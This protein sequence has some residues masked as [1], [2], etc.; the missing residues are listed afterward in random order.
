MLHI[1]KLKQGQEKTDKVGACENFDLKKD[2]DSISNIVYGK[3]T[4]METT[5]G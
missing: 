3:T 1:C 4:T 2:Q 5:K